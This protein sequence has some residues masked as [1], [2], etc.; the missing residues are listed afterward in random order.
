MLGVVPVVF[1][2]GVMDVDSTTCDCMEIVGG[3]LLIRLA[4]RLGFVS[5]G[6]EGRVPGS[7]LELEVVAV[8]SISRRLFAASRSFVSL[9]RLRLRL[10]EGSFANVY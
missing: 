6:C 4:E 5:I 8:R 9:F 1:G 7:E 2:S 10:N 3:A